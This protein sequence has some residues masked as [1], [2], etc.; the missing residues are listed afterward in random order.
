MNNIDILS[1]AELKLIDLEDLGETKCGVCGLRMQYYFTKI[2]SILIYIDFFK[3]SWQTIN[4]L[5]NQFDP[6]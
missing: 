4:F 6:Y 3:L 1:R 2:L 5:F